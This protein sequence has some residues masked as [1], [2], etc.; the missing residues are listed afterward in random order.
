MP[1]E[2]FE[3]G[4]QLPCVLCVCTLLKKEETLVAIKII[5]LHVSMSLIHSVNMCF[6]TGELS[7][8]LLRDISEQ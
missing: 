3:R 8:L 7:P 4:L 5:G 2:Y 6:L 1:I